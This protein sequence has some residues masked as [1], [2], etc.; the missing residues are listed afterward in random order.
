MKPLVLLITHTH[1]HSHLT[2]IHMSRRTLLPFLI[3]V[4]KI[5]ERPLRAMLTSVLMFMVSRDYFFNQMW[6]KT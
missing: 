3:S 5:Q 6:T 1:T 4:W 2:H